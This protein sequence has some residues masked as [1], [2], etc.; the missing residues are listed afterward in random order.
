MEKITEDGEKNFFKALDNRF[1]LPSKS[2]SWFNKDVHGQPSIEQTSW[3][4]KWYVTVTKSRLDV[5]FV[6][7]NTLAMVIG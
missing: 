5:K 1:W 4:G 2:Y 3:K 7:K 6:K